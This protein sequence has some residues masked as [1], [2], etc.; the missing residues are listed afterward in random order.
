MKDR[1]SVLGCL[2]Q[3]LR[4]LGG[5][6]SR[7]PLLHIF[8]P[9]IPLSQRRRAARTAHHS[10]C[11]G[12]PN[13][14]IITSRADVALQLQQQQ[15]Q[16]QGSRLRTPSAAGGIGPP[17]KR[18]KR[19]W[20]LSRSDA[21]RRIAAERPSRCTRRF[22]NPTTPPGKINTAHMQRAERAYGN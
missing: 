2:G 20:Q 10:Q 9:T 15:Q 5:T 7:G 22:Y 12:M 14:A 21:R 17:A 1:P 13:E 18:L 3:R 8:S 6:Y 16:Q 19:Q 11:H 4:A